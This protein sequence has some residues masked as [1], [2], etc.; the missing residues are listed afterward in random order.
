MPLLCSGCTKQFAN[1]FKLANPRGSTDIQFIQQTAFVLVHCFYIE[2]FVLVRPNMSDTCKKTPETL[3]EVDTELYADSVEWCPFE[4]YGYFFVGAT[5]QLLTPEEQSNG[6]SKRTGYLQ[7]YEWDQTG[8]AALK[9]HSRINTVGI[10]D[11]K[12]CGQLFN[13]NPVFACVDSNGNLN[14][15]KFRPEKTD[16]ELITSVSRDTACIALSLSWSSENNETSKPHITSSYSTGEV[17]VYEFAPTTL[18]KMNT[19]KAHNFEA[20]ICAFDKHNSTVVYS[21]GDDCLFKGWDTRSNSHTF[22]NR[23]HEMGVCSMHSNPHRENILATG[24]YDENVRIWDTR[25]IRKS[26]LFCTHVRGGVWRLKWSPK[27]ENLL[28]AACMH[29]GVTILDCSTSQSSSPTP[30]IK[31]SNHK[32]LAYGADWS[33]AD[34]LDRALVAT[35]SFYDHKLCVWT[36]EK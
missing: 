36:Y 8:N 27:D 22:I 34:F 23:S 19:W 18:T 25:C 10:L 12:W 21:G 3:A 14:T 15:Y 24:S 1:F 16:L 11:V 29:N 6:S 7:L 26:P 17:Q 28:L 9:K 20:W 35:C 31:Y 33:H 13:E 32:S 5:Y 2:V 30:I 4:R